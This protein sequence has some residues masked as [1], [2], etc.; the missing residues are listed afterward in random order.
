M[1]LPPLL[2]LLPLPFKILDAK[3]PDLFFWS[4]YCRTPKFSQSNA[5]WKMESTRMSQNPYALHALKVLLGY[6]TPALFFKCIASA[7]PGSQPASPV[8]S[9]RQT[10]RLAAFPAWVKQP[11]LAAGCHLWKL[12][13]NTCPERIPTVK[14]LFTETFL[15]HCNITWG[16]NKK[17][18]I[19]KKSSPANKLYS[20]LY[21]CYLSFITPFLVRGLPIL[22][23]C[24][25]TSYASL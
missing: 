4:A 12:R 16:R 9:S 3:E 5:P 1:I 6:E 14:I 24:Y 23:H 10:S 7:A 19:F 11:K 17:I 20:S 2:P 13:Q 21:S 22:A 15:V 25:M 18:W 8:S